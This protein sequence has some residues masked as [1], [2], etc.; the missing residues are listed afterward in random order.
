[1]RP[2]EF[3]GFLSSMMAAES[4]YG[5]RAVLH[6][7]GGC[8]FHDSALSP[9]KVT[10]EYHIREGPFYF[11]RPRIP[12]TYLDDEDY[13]NGA[14]YK[15]TDLLDT[16]D[17]ADICVILTSP[18]T[19]LIGDDLNGAAYRSKY[20][21]ITVIPEYCHMS[22]P[23][24]VGYDSTI[25]AMVRDACQKKDRIKGTVN[26]LGIP[27]TLEGWTET[28]A[29]FRGYLE[30]MGLKVVSVPGGGCTTAEFFNSPSAEFNVTVIPEYCCLTAEMY[31]RLGISTIMP[32]T[33][34]G[35]DATRRWI[36]AVASHAGVDA[37]PA[38]ALLNSQTT[39]CS[40]II[41][42]A[43]FSGLV[44]KCA[45]YSLMSD[46]T[47]VLPLVKW[48]HSYLSMFPVHIRACPWW[49]PEYLDELKKF[50]VSIH[51]EDVISDEFKEV[52]SDVL[53]CYGNLAELMEKKGICGIGIDIQIPTHHSLEF[54]PK[55]VLGARGVMR[56]LDEIYYGMQ[57]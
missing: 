16:V 53:F 12:C 41:M 7:P 5:S 18:G 22:E 52:R 50:L 6:G 21:G 23:A 35:F 4:M 31:E 14:D 51:C 11:N 3:D 55:P 43:Q 19:S 56:M 33:P 32:E 20:K 38:L 49:T 2:V 28:S 47:M 26:L 36:L 9:S 34:A 37:G 42:S 46:S 15:I 17:D 10:R 48:L 1:M 40:R 29:E 44:T 25:S 54:V 13:I 27:V 24:H 57:R 30:A 8:R 45:S 39:R